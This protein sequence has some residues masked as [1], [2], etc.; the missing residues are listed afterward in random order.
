MSYYLEM[1]ELT[2]S[3]CPPTTKWMTIITCD[4]PF[5]PRWTPALG[6]IMHCNNHQQSFALRSFGSTQID[7][8][9]DKAENGKQ[10]VELII[11]ARGKTGTRGREREVGDISHHD[12][13][14]L[15]SPEGGKGNFS[16]PLSLAHSRSAVSLFFRSVDK[17][18]S[19]SYYRAFSSAFFQTIF[20]PLF[21]IDS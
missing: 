14:Y 20:P 17:S 6:Q 10:N 9:T 2:L 7:G 3:P 5:K 12:E 4:R 1:D 13:K 16:Y 18:P 21:R 19:D 15:S 8:H 11:F